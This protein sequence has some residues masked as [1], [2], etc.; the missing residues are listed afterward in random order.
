LDFEPVYRFDRRAMGDAM[1]IRGVLAGVALVVA[2]S[3]GAW[4]QPSDFTGKWL[5]SGLIIGPGAATSFAQ[6]CDLQQT[7]SQL[8]GPCHGPNGGCSLVGVISGGAVDLTCRTSF[9]NNPGLAGVTTFQGALAADGIVRGVVV[10]SRA[11][12]V[13]GQAAMMRI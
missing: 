11:P 3:G 4:A 6:I 13:R 12:G 8:A 10:H 7:G 1:R 2:I 9:T 5:F